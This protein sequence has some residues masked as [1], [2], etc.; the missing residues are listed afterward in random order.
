[1][2]YIKK[3]D[4][5]RLKPILSKALIADKGELCYGISQLMM[6]FVKAKGKP[7]SYQ[8]LSDARAA[9]IDAAFEWQD[10]VMRRYED[11]KIRENGDIFQDFIRELNI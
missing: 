9:A 7:L 5:E 8:T 10:R 1:M 11:L 2:P 3:H 4:Q 6:S